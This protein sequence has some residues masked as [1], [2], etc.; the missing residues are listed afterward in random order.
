MVALALLRC[1][2]WFVGVRLVG[3][4][5][6][7]ASLHWP[8]HLFLQ[9][10]PVLAGLLISDRQ[11]LFAPHALLFLSTLGLPCRLYC[12]LIKSPSNDRPTHTHQMTG[13]HT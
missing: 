4:V 3:A 13:A 10:R 5:E 6:H 1:R 2:S 11:A 9:G 8:T 7:A 12:N